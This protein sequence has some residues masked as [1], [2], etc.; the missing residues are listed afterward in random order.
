[1]STKFG[2]SGAAYLDLGWARRLA[3]LPFSSVELARAG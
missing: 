1:M 2:I 3:D